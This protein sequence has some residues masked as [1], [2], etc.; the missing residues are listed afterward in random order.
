M[1]GSGSSAQSCRRLAKETIRTA[2]GRRC[3]SECRAQPHFG[4]NILDSSLRSWS[5]GVRQE[6]AAVAAMASSAG[7]LATAAGEVVA[8]K[9]AWVAAEAA[10]TARAWAATV[11][12]AA[13]SAVA[14]PSAVATVL[15]HLL[16]ME[17]RAGAAIAANMTEVG[18][19]VKTMRQHLRRRILS[20]TS[21]TA[22]G[23]SET[24]I[25][26]QSQTGSQRWPACSKSARC[27][28]GSSIVGSAACAAE[29]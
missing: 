5:T 26:P 13:R 7:P 3:N 6:A 25:C 12:S 22:R 28:L 29:L 23:A 17:R 16:L 15:E 18:A 27:L 10:A 19:M 11:R 2:R 9:A 14:A 4:S 1:D 8:A 20:Q 21:R 24:P